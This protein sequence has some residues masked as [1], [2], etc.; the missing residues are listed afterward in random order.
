MA[1]CRV[2]GC[3]LAGI[4]VLKIRPDLA[5]RSR[6]GRLNALSFVQMCVCVCVCVCVCKH[7]GVCMCRLV[8]TWL[9]HLYRRVVPTQFAQCW[10]EDKL[11]VKQVDTSNDVRVSSIPRDAQDNCPR[12][13]LVCMALA[14]R[15]R[16]K[17]NPVGLK[18]SAS[19]CMA[20]S[21]ERMCEGAGQESHPRSIQSDKANWVE[22]QTSQL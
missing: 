16:H 15:A 3:F 14:R 22:Q 6:K 18:K 10:W 5:Q 7:V 4:G 1:L 9:G 17:Q 13:I 11:D 21:F 2:I 20:D 12:G 19:V 8:S